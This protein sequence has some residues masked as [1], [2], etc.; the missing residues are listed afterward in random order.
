MNPGDDRAMHATATP[1]IPSALSTGTRPAAPADGLVSRSIRQHFAASLAERRRLLLALWET[2]RAAPGDRAARARLTRHLRVLADAA[3]RAGATAVESA[4]RAADR[5]LPHV[6]DGD[7]R[8]MERL[9]D[10]ALDAMAAV[11]QQDAPSIATR[12]PMVVL[13]GPDDERP[14]WLE[15]VLAASGCQIH[16]ASGLALLPPLAAGHVV[17]VGESAASA[18]RLAEWRASI[19]ASGRPARLAVLAGGA[20]YAQRCRWLAADAVLPSSAER[21][22]LLGAVESE[23]SALQAPLQ[24]VALLG[25]DAGLPAWTDAMS[26]AGFLVIAAAEPSDL[27][28]LTR[29][30]GLDAIVAGPAVSDRQAIELACALA[31][32]SDGAR[33]EMLRL[34]AGDDDA[35]GLLAAGIAVVAGDLCPTDCARALGERLRRTRPPLAGDIDPVSGALRRAPFLLLVQGMLDGPAAFVGLGLIDLDGLRTLHQQVGREAGEHALRAI[36]R[37]LR[38]ALPATAALGRAGMD[39]FLFAF[40]ARNEAEARRLMAQAASLPAEG[41]GAARIEHC[42]GGVLLDRDDRTERVP[43]VEL[44]ARAGE[45]ML[46]GKT[47][48]GSRISLARYG[49]RPIGE[50]WF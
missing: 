31:Q 11:T 12:L 3:A 25:F 26:A 4:A 8:A 16:R 17:V 7:A 24:C 40:T 29:D 19:V 38:A 21:P 46:D 48:H 47:G 6:A 1:L 14:A 44:V 2:M 18:D 35:A 49:E 9:V 13:D 23:L 5:S 43:L 41:D 33:V 36:T 15:E 37:R 20:G 42:I 22:V 27:W 30:G 50:R 34:R 32:D 45:L 28:R 39:E 10:A